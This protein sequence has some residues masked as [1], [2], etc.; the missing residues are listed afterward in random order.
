[1]KKVWLVVIATLIVFGS[2]VNAQEDS[3]KDSP[4]YKFTV[5]KEIPTTSV[6]SQDRSGT[7]WSFSTISFIESEIIRKGLGEYDLS[8]MFIVRNTYFDKGMKYVR[9]HGKLNFGAGGAFH[10]V[11]YVMDKYGLVPETVYPGLNYGKDIHIHNHGELDD[12]TVAFLDA[13]IKNSNKTLTTAWK[14]AYAG[15]LDAYLGDY[16]TTFKYNGESFTPKTFARKLE[17]NASDYVEIGSYT[18][19]PF[20]EQFVLE[21]PDNW[22]YD[23]INNLPLDEMMEVM[24][25]ALENGYSIAWG[26]DVSEKGFSWKNGIAIVPSE[27][28]PDLSGTE[29]EKW[30]KLT[31]SEK[32][33]ALYKFD[34]IVPEKVITQEMRQEGFDNYSTTDDHGM[35]ITG[36]ARDQEGNKYFIVKNSWG[37]NNHIYDGYFYASEAFV[38]LK[39]IDFVVHKDAIP[40]K[41]RKKL[42]L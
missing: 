8:E 3:K 6:K 39:T 13:V 33:R 10:D 16:P 28:R 41:I 7:C 2:S 29:K 5:L 15:I 4:A 24:Y 42:G 25:Y 17:L 21:V 18:H 1:M 36:L 23:K 31:E 9:F 14:N 22:M 35:H 32:K 11:F 37:N 38:R 34:K 19:H 40:K 26:A 20:Y 30:E 12:V 27:E